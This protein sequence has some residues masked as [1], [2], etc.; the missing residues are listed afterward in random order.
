[1]NRLRRLS[2][3]F[4]QSPWLDNL[5]RDFLSSGALAR[6]VERGVRGLTSN[7]TIFQKAIQGSNDYDGQFFDLTNHG[8]SVEEAYWELVLSDI[9]GALDVFDAVHQESVGKDGFVSVEVDPRLARDGDATLLAARE[10]HERIGRSNAMIKIPATLEGL[11]AIRSMIAEG[12]SVNVTLIFGLDRY[13]AVIEAYLSGLEDLASNPSS[14]LAGVSSVASFFI[15][16]VDSEVDARLAAIGTPAAGE[17]QGHA[18]VVQAKLAYQL[19]ERSFTGPRWAALAARG[20]RPQRPLW[21]STSTKNPQYP[22]TMYVD[23]LI[24]PQSVNTLPDQTLEAFDDHGLP[25][26]TIDSSLDEAHDVW[27]R[28]SKVGIDMA[29][30]AKKLEIEGIASF[31]ASFSDLLDAL[32]AKAAA[33]R[34]SPAGGE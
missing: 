5:R 9:N 6:L 1:M 20:A 32:A 26:R 21:A 27:V 16:R 12:R 28:L 3:E 29:E 13:A 17:L 4:D 14:D 15:S 10:L 19:F 7:P 2:A 24:G 18:A 25:A 11:G 23:R 22:D 33:G 31:E 8:V 34:P 30:V